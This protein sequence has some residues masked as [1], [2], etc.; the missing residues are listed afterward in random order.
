MFQSLKGIQDL[1]SLDK[2]S[3]SLRLRN[4]MK[5]N[6]SKTRSKEFLKTYRLPIWLIGWD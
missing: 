2:S 1:P 3:R 5:K 4:I 6:F